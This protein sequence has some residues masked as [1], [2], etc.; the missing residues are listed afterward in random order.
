MA[1]RNL[2]FT[3]RVNA[4]AAQVYRAFTS[5]TALREW[6]CNAAQADARVGGRLYLWWSSGYY[7]AGEFTALTPNQ[8]IA[9]TW[10]GRGEPG[11]TRVVVTLTEKPDGTRVSV[12]HTGVAVGKAWTKATQEF[13]SGWQSA[14]ENLQATLETGLD[15]RFTRRPMLGINVGILNAKEAKKLRVPVSVGIRLDG[16]GE[17][18]GAQAAD[19]RTDDVIVKMGG[20]PIT[21][22]TSLANVLQTHRAGDELT[23]V[24]Y[25]GAKKHTVKM[26][27][28]ARPLPEVPP[29]APA[30]ADAVR[31]SYAE[32]F[33][34]LAECFDGVSE[35]E[36]ERCPK[37]GEWSAKET[38]AHLIAGERDNHAWLSDLLNDAE[39]WYDNNDAFDNVPA[40]LTAMVQAYPSI[41]DL[42]SEF[43]R[44]QT[45]T[46]AIIAA[47]PKA[48]VAHKAT[49][50]RV[51]A[52]LLQANVHTRAH[53]P[54]IRTAVET[55]GG[56]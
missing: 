28:S 46:V 2:K 32:Q 37:P 34:E 19:L 16:V 15:L 20:K 56:V 17:G 43:K 5:S 10:Q 44:V 49:Y 11:L 3:R 38:L 22:Y 25:R 54:Q 1:T 33:A 39:R 12:R 4:P 13:S 14:L 36:A 9:F 50:W 35:A 51:G 45:E 48:F 40:R 53:L 30:L 24:F 47:L 23:V 42:L 6:F 26:Q 27:L 41:A 7:T 31:A 52:N 18:T 21:G 8:R 29:T 55:P